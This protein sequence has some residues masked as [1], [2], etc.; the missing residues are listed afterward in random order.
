VLQQRPT[1][2]S[3]LLRAEQPCNGD[4]S[5]FIGYTSWVDV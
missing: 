2:Y 1:A 3:H 4:V 5:Y